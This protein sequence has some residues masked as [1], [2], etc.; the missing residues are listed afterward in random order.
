[1]GAECAEDE[2]VGP[3]A[4]AVGWCILKANHKEEFG[5]LGC[6]GVCLWFCEESE[7]QTAVP[8]GAPGLG[9]PHQHA[10][11]TLGLGTTTSFPRLL[12]SGPITFRDGLGNSQQLCIRL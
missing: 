9:G 4:A 5:I 1:M 2:V 7:S 3:K 10:V 11:H 8:P 6:C 12:A